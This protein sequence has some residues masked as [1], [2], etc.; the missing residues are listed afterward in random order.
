MDGWMEWCSGDSG[1]YNA[2]SQIGYVVTSV[3]PDFVILGETDNYNF[4]KIQTAINCVNQGS[5]LIA[6]NLDLFDPSVNGPIPAAGA[7]I[8][9]IEIVTGRKAY[10]VG[11]PNPLMMR[12][13]LKLLG[14]SAKDAV[15]IGDRMDTDIIA[16][17][18]G[19]IDTVLVLSGVSSLATLNHFA[20]RPHHI[21]NTLGDLLMEVTKKQQQPAS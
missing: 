16:G 1:I 5:K 19:D 4:D 18:E 21:V 11:K 12:I 20:Y 8:S 3:N 2:L 7:L 15:V 17:L 13:A 10:S 6:T 9:P 14:H